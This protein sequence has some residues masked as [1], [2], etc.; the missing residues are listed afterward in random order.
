M[1]DIA[2][3]AGAFILGL[4]CIVAAVVLALYDKVIPNE[5]LVLPGVALGILGGSYMAKPKIEKIR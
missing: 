3:I 5:F 1:K 4:A 2:V